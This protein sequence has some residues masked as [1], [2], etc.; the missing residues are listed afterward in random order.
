MKNLIR[1]VVV[2][3][4]CTFAHGSAADS[5]CGVTDPQAVFDAVQGTWVGR[6]SI[7]VETETLSATEEPNQMVLAITPA[8]GLIFDPQAGGSTPLALEAEGI[9]YD[10]DQVDDILETVEAEWIA[11]DVSL[12]PCGPEGLLQLT[13]AI[14]LAEGE[15]ASVILLPYFSDRLVMIGEREMRG[16]FGL[17]FV[18]MAA[19][20]TPQD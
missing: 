16:D 3:S 4:S 1:A 17:A 9:V 20:L 18:T 13:V 15:T 11:D 8:G 6:G 2:L 10:V 14:P 7:N 19:L 12:T 5:L